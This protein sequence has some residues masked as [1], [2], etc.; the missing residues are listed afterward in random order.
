MSVYVDSA[1]ASYG[2]MKMCHM[3]ADTSDEL[4]SMADQIGVAR[5]WIQHPGTEKEHYDIC[6]AAR[7]KAIRLGAIVVNPRGIAAI[8]HWKRSRDVD[9]ARGPLLTDEHRGAA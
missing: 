9:L 6:K 4:H 5:R 8:L 2:R 7:T 3:L 1:F